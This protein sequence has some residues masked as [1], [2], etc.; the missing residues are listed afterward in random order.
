MV[1][2]IPPVKEPTQKRN[3]QSIPEEKEL[4]IPIPVNDENDHIS[5]KPRI[6]EEPESAYTD[7]EISKLYFGGQ[8][9]FGGS[10]KKKSQKEIQVYCYYCNQ[11]ISARRL[12]SHECTGS[13]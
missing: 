9:Y 4:P 1:D 6:Q 10:T 5:K 7:E 11:T 8:T 2:S 12:L 3:I 13:S